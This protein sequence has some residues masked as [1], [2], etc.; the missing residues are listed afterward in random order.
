M[1]RNNSPNRNN[2]A[3]QLLAL[4]P[5]LIEMLDGVQQV[6]LEDF[7]MEIGDL[8]LFI[9]KGASSS[10]TPAGTPPALRH[11]LPENLLPTP[12]HAPSAEYSG[13]IRGLTLR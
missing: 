8:S 13:R 5:R 12:F 9:P 4:A 2:A 11:D 6:E 1:A 10:P 7:A 3:D